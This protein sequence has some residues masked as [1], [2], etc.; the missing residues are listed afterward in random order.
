M[1]RGTCLSADVAIN[2]SHGRSGV[3]LELM[4]TVGQHVKAVLQV[5]LRVPRPRS[6]PRVFDDEAV[7]ARGSEPLGGRVSQRRL[8]DDEAVLKQPNDR[9]VP[10]S[11][12]GAFV[13]VYA[14][15]HVR[16]HVR[17][18]CVCGVCGAC[19]CACV[20]TLMYAGIF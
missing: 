19:A 17:G 1:E 10:E 16:T 8:V 18:E 15:V 11:T 7:D 3:R 14:G 2:V 9:V 6:F 12:F 5:G 20:C 4:Y 13:C